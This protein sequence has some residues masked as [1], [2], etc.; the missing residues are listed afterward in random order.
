MSGINHS[1]DG[2][3]LYQRGELFQEI[4]QR[5]PQGGIVPLQG[6]EFFGINC[7]VGIGLNCH[8]VQIVGAAP[9]ERNQL[10]NRRKVNMK[11]IPTQG[12]F[13][14]I[15][16]HITDA[17]L[18]HTFLNQ[19][20]LRLRHHHMKLDRT[21]ALFCHRSSRSRLRRLGGCSRTL[22]SGL[23]DRGGTGRLLMMPS[24]MFPFCSIESSAFLLGLCS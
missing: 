6:R 18:R 10:T 4:R 16:S 12:H 15:G 8:L 21:A 14:H 1:P 23:S 13:P 5:P 20:L 3:E 19:G 9:L 24:I 2:S 7:A 17:S 22:S 11:H